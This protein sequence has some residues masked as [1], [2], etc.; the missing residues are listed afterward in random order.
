MM[1]CQAQNKKIRPKADGPFGRK[2]KIFIV[3]VQNLPLYLEPFLEQE[4]F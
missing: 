3:L 4:L 1:F 2:F